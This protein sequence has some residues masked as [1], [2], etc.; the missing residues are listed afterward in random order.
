M[1]LLAVTKFEL[2]C[3]GGGSRGQ[4]RASRASSGCV[5]RIG[6]GISRAVVDVLV[7][8]YKGVAKV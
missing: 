6:G 4:C 1:R 7:M 5:R 8:V 2:A 3:G